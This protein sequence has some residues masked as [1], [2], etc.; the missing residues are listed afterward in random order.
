MAELLHDESYLSFTFIVKDILPSVAV[1]GDVL[2]SSNF[3]FW[4]QNCSFVWFGSVVVI[5]S[6]SVFVLAMPSSM[7]NISFPT[8]NPCLLQWKCGVL[9]PVGFQG[10]PKTCFESLSFGVVSYC[11]YSVPQLCLTLCDPVDCSTPGFPVLHHLPELARTHVHWVG[12]AIQPSHPLS[13]SF[14]PAPNPSQYQGL[15]QWV[16][17]SNQMAKVLE[18]QLLQHQSFQWIFKTDFL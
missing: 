2:S 11:C 18:P 16:S 3:L 1:N 8:R 5:T 9:K 12:D 7:Q 14:P 13:S 17:S 10:I 15:F 6:G 4:W